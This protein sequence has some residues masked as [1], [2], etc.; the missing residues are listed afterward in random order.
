MMPTKYCIPYFLIRRFGELANN[1][2]M[3]QNGERRARERISRR[4][5][6]HDHAD[7]PARFFVLIRMVAPTGVGALH[8]TGFAR[9][10]AGRPLAASTL[11]MVA[12]ISAALFDF[13]VAKNFVEVFSPNGSRTRVPTVRG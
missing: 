11:L 13:R 2:T 6:V 8:V 9:V 10:V 4:L 7:S 1:D 3:L 5:E 12:S